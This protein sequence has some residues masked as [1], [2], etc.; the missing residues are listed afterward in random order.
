MCCSTR[1]TPQPLSSAYWRTTGQQPLDD[2][3]GQAEAELVEEQERRAPRE[4]PPDGEHLLLAAGE[5]AAAPVAKLGQR[6]EV[7]VRHI[8]VEALAAVAEA[9]VLGDGEP[10][11]EAAVLRDV[12]DAELRARARLTRAADP[13]PGSGSR[14][15]SGGRGRRRR[16]ASS[17]CPRRSR[18]AAR[19][20]RPA[21]RR[22]GASRITAAP[23]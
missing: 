9:E 22:R 20:S 12:R 16:E 13:A 8:G 17:S 5:E 21:R 10:E 18:R 7:P 14:R 6:G 4:R 15:P 23:S 11:E 19:R 3:R 1:T 2:H